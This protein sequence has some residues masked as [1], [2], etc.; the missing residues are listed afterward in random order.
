MKTKDSL[1]I[2]L[3]VRGCADDAEWAL[4][5]APNAI[6][7]DGYHLLREALSAVHVLSTYANDKI[8]EIEEEEDAKQ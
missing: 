1:A 5:K 8:C 4:E 2:W 7:P 6:D 3:A